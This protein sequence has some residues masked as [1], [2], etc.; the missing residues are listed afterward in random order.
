MK[1][2]ILIGLLLLVPM[3]VSAAPFLVCDPQ[4]G[5]TLYKM[6]GPSWVPLT[7]TAQADGSIKMDVA[8]AVIGVTSVTAAA[9]ITDASWPDERCSVPVPFSFTRPANPVTP[10]NIKLAP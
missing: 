4:A 1:K 2:F 5:V 9:C 6:T 3:V 10:K 7:I 8:S